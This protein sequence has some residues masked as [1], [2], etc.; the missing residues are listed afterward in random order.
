MKRLV[1]ML[2]VLIVAP[3]V[4][5]DIIMTFGDPVD[6]GS[7]YLPVTAGLGSSFDLV[8]ARIAS[9]GDIFES[10]AATNFSRAGWD[11]LLDGPTLAS[12]CG[13]PTSHLSWRMHF[14]N[15]LDKEVT[16]DWAIFAG[17]N[18][19]WTS[20]YTLANGQI[21]IYEPRSQYWLPERADLIPAPGALL[22]GGIGA[23]IV[24]WLR[25]RNTV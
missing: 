18:R 16:I 19:I 11:M 12:F 23:G 4:R 2:C 24:G 21:G 25:R 7:W 1:L 9:S 15:D 20:R 3:C 6:E 8:G 13:P 10:P 22:L 5:A 17:D 14:A